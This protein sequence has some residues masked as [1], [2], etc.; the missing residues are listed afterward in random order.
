MPYTLGICQFIKEHYKLKKYKFIGASAGSWLSIYL[1]SDM[2]L[3]DDLIKDYSKLFENR[4]ILYKWHNI[5]PF[6]ADE[7]PKYINDFSFIKNK[8]IEVSISHYE[9]KTITNELIN[10]YN[11]IEELLQLCTFS[12]YIPIL[13]GFSIPKRNNLISFDGYFSEPNFKNKKIILKID[14][15]MFDR[16]FTFSDVIGKTKININELINLGY[17]DCI[18]NK[19]YLDE[20][21]NDF[22]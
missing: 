18:I 13:S 22:F 4:G 9:N 15:S 10:D 6:L 2:Y 1:A 12:S 19:K 21:F 5:C 14:N 17:Y 3:S 20:L 7:F 11:N 16:H 8:K